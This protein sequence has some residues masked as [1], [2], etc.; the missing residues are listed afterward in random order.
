MSVTVG[1]VPA[2]AEAGNP[3]EVFHGDGR[4][5]MHWPSPAVS[6]EH[7]IGIRAGIGTRAV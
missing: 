2:E 5:P 6:Q 7:R 4:A 3:G 1:A